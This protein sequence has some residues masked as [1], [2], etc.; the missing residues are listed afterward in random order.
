MTIGIWVLGDQLWQQQS[1]LDSC[2]EDK[3][4]TPVILIESSQYVRQRLYQRDDFINFILT[5]NF[6]SFC[7]F[8]GN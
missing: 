4:Q 8:N 5:K 1:A 3:Q 7:Q 6:F 2:R